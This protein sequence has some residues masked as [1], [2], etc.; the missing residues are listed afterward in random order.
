MHLAKQK[1][2][3]KRTMFLNLFIQLALLAGLVI[4]LPPQEPSSEGQ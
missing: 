2:T 4:A 3:P 1:R